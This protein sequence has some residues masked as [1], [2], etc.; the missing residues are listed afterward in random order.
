MPAAVGEGRNLSANEKDILDYGINPSF[1]DRESLFT[2][3]CS[4]NGQC[5]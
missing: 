4:D 2:T 5:I 1:K 3:V